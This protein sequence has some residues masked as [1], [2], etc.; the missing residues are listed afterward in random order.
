MVSFLIRQRLVSSPDEIDCTFRSS[1]VLCS[2]KFS[3][4]KVDQYSFLHSV[5]RR[6]SAG[7]V[8]EFILLN[9]M[10]I[11]VIKW[12]SMVFFSLCIG[13]NVQD[14]KRWFV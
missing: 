12:A 4:E 10:F 5:Y 2:L 11:V 3:I 8:E 13:Y 7:H 6:Q 9:D 14:M 1:V